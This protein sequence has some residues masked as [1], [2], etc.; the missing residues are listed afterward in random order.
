MGRRER[1]LAF[2]L[3]WRQL[4]ACHFGYRIRRQSMH[5]VFVARWHKTLSRKPL[6]PF[7]P[8]AFLMTAGDE[9]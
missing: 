7:L 2:T 1:L 6:K 4:V 3:L 9:G 5:D 8:F